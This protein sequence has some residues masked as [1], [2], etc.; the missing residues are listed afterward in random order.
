MT[1]NQLMREQNLET[2]R[3][4]AAYEAEVNRH[5][6][7]GEV[8]E[9]ERNQIDKEYKSRMAANAEAM[10]ALEQMKLDWEKERDYLK[11][12]G[13]YPA[14]AAGMAAVSPDYI[15]RATDFFH[16]LNDKPSFHVK[17]GKDESV[18]KALARY[19]N[20]LIGEAD[21]I[22]TD[23]DAAIDRW[24]YSNSGYTLEYQSMINDHYRT[25]LDLNTKQQEAMAR[26]ANAYKDVSLLPED[27][28]IRQAEAYEKESHAAYQ[29]WLNENIM[30]MTL[31]DKFNDSADSFVDMLKGISYIKS[32]GGSAS[33]K[34]ID[35]SKRWNDVNKSPA[36][37]AAEELFK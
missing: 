20:Y 13:K 19:E 27:R 35:F 1:A 3:H 29:D 31:W 16:S 22:K 32:F 2:A 15:W 25:L 36:Y 23:W 18:D 12:F 33:S 8:I 30:W 5:N 34:S 9:Q 4:N 17:D 24:L 21:A 28:R 10:T 26:F 14:Q 6:Q 7:Q 11:L 37:R